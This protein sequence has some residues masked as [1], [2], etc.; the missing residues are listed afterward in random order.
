MSIFIRSL[1]IYKAAFVL[2]VETVS[3]KYRALAAGII[4]ASFP[5]GGILLGVIAM[6]VHDILILMRILYGSGLLLI[7]Y[8]WIA[9]ESVRWLLV[10]GRVDRAI[11]V[12]KRIA[13]VN[14]KELSTKSIEM[15]TLKYSSRQNNENDEH[16]S[17]DKQN[18]PENVSIINVFLTI[19]KSKKL[20]FRIL[21]GCYQWITCCY[22]YYGLSLVSI[23]IPGADRYMSYLLVAI[24]EFPG[25]L[26]PI[27][28]S[29]FI[30]RKTLLFFSLFLTGIAIIVTPWI[31]KE[32]PMIVLAMFMIGKASITCAFNLLYMYTAEQWP[33]NARITIMSTCSMIGRI[34]SGKFQIK[35]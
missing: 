2:G 22:C 33:T 32:H 3:S 28:L 24:I 16:E 1:G 11:I 14:R 6:Y 26:A 17:D 25:A 19:L 18:I 29:K 4:A 9:P 5:L 8:I 7:V 31:P 10:T 35:I 21:N 34:G 23:H 13:S 20:S 12:L 27:P 15:I 30:H